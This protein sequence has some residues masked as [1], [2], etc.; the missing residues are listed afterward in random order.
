MTR[1]LSKLATTLGVRDQLLKI[2]DD[3][4]RYVSTDMVSGQLQLELL[5]RQGCQPTSK[6]LELGCGCLH[7]GIP[8]L[9]FLNES[10]YVGV[11]PNE[12]LRQSA[13]KDAEV[14]HLVAAKKAQFLSVDDFDASS[15]GMKFDLV[16][17]HSVLSHAAHWQLD[18]YLRNT[19]KVLAPGGR[20]LASLC[21]AEGNAYGNSGTPDKQD[22]MDKE[23]VYPGSSW[24][25]LSTI[26]NTAAKL[27]LTADYMP[28]YSEFYTKTHPNESHD[29]IVFLRKEEV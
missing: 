23:W 20:I 6:V 26:E 27:G 22:S 14:R 18:T 11:D 3:P 21:L 29:W 1:L 7:L 25:K 15:L 10:N 12:W 17:S 16:F 13:M 19:A 4:K 9:R 28:E 8:L 24:F 2:M 5:K